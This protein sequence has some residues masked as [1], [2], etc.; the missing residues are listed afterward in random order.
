M[1]GTVGLASV[2]KWT[3]METAQVSPLSSEEAQETEEKPA[4]VC[5]YFS[6]NVFFFFSVSKAA[7]S[8][9]S[10]EDSGEDSSDR[11][12]VSPLSSELTFLSN[13]LVLF[14]EK[15]NIIQGRL[16]LYFF[17]LYAIYICVFLVQILLYQQRQGSI[18]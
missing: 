7:C 12:Q 11:S 3:H 10:P 13:V 4:R 6:P 16:V 9:T 17:H 1:S 8:A 5:V 15:Q 18:N 2:L 14:E